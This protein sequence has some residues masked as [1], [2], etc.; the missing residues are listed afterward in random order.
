MAIALDKLAMD[1]AIVYPLGLSVL[2]WQPLM[3]I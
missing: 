3:D 2:G 1:R